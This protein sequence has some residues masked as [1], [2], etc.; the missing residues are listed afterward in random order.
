M[1]L[2]LQYFIFTKFSLQQSLIIPADIVNPA[3]CLNIQCA[4]VLIS[5]IYSFYRNGKIFESRVYKA[6]TP[7][8]SLKFWLASSQFKDVSR[9]ISQMQNSSNTYLLLLT[10]HLNEDIGRI[11]SILFPKSEQMRSLCWIWRLDGWACVGGGGPR[12]CPPL[13]AGYCSSSDYF[14]ASEICL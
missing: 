14:C 12:N 6:L 7:S 4:G 1:V 11:L 2:T 3:S 8:P 10:L 9:C 13:S 5:F